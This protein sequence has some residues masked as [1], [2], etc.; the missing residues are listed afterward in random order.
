M[1]MLGQPYLALA[2]EWRERHTQKERER[3]SNRERQGEGKLLDWD[4]RWLRQLNGPVKSW[5]SVAIGCTG[6]GMRVIYSLWWKGPGRGSSGTWQVHWEEGV[7]SLGNRNQR[8]GQTSMTSGVKCTFSPLEAPRQRQKALFLLWHYSCVNRCAYSVCA[9]LSPNM[10]LGWF[11]AMRTKQ[12]WPNQ[13]PMF[14]VAI[15]ICLLASSCSRLH[16]EH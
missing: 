16:G 12:G 2:E 5:R 9:R 11:R 15:I 8:W 1:L 14:W 10:C 6:Q 13:W 7:S 3:E 4:S